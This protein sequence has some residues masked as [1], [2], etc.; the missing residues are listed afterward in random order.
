MGID[1]SGEE[2][3][4]DNLL[5]GSH[6]AGAKEEVPLPW[7]PWENWAEMALASCSFV[8]PASAETAWNVKERVTLVRD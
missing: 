1:L 3:E 2:E 4:K 6:S 5:L 7:C 8:I